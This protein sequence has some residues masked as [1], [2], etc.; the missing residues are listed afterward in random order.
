MSATHPIAVFCDVD[1]V[2]TDMPINMQLAT[3][4][5]V[6]GG[7]TE[8]EAKFYK[9]GDT[10]AFNRDF[11]PLFRGAGFNANKAQE[12]FERVELRNRAIELI[13]LEGVDIY[14]VTSG[15]S[16]YLD[17]LANQHGLD[18]DTRCT[19]S[20]YKFD[21]NGSLSANG[22]A[23]VGEAAKRSFV[24]KHA[25]KYSLTVGVGNS[26]RLDG[27]FLA[28][29]SVPILI[30]ALEKAFLCVNELDTVIETIGNLAEWAST[31]Q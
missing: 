7:L 27:L 15:P 24:K 3:F 9:D 28:Q 22:W 10:D 6:E 23:A 12:Y 18:P 31:Q 16:F 19:C 8:I 5:G 2:L 1:D 11:I 21:D 20:R 30:G 26:V 13:K 25:K 17:L 4:M 29:C 14:L